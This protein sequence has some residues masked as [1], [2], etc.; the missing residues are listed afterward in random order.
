MAAAP[1]AGKDGEATGAEAAA[2]HTSLT[3]LLAQVRELCDEYER[4]EAK[5][6]GGA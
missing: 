6:A 2:D 1:G 3:P 4:L 5:R